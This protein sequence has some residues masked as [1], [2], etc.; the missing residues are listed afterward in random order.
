MKRLVLL[1]GVLVGSMAALGCRSD[2]QRCEDICETSD[3]CSDALNVDVCIDECTRDT[4]YADDSCSASFSAMADCMALED[5]DCPDS[6]D[7][8]DSEIEDFFEDCEDDFAHFEYADPFLPAVD[9][10][11]MPL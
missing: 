9:N 10:N 3:D 7:S 5:H 6:I 2:S 8:C 1:V 11:P 4:D